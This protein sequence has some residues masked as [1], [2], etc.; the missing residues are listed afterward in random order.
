MAEVREITFN[1]R[2][3]D[4]SPMI[5]GGSG[6]GLAEESLAGGSVLLHVLR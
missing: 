4:R 2:T 3:C 1:A 5:E 6:S